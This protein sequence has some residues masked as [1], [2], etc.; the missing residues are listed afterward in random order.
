MWSPGPP[1]Q[2]STS[3]GYVPY[4]AACPSEPAPQQPE[5]LQET[6]HA[7]VG[8]SAQAQ[9]TDWQRLRTDNF[10]HTVER[11]RSLPSELELAGEETPTGD[12]GTVLVSPP[13]SMP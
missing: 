3:R 7:E 13:S 11:A 4:S 12:G 2:A 8:H 9:Q 6:A 1:S 5:H 10:G